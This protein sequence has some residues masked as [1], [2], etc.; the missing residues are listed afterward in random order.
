MVSECIEGM[1]ERYLQEMSEDDASLRMYV[2]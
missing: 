2:V 1:F